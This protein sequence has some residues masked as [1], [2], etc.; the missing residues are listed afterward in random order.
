MFII[1]SF[2]VDLPAEVDDEYWENNDPT[3][4]FQQPYGKPAKVTFF[5]SFVKLTH[6]IS[7]ALRTIV[8]KRKLPSKHH[9]DLIFLQYAIN[10]SKLKIDVPQGSNWKEAIV[11]KMNTMMTEWV[12]TVPQHRELYTIHTK[13][14]YSFSNASQMVT[15]NAAL[16][17]C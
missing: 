17:I 1:P 11:M 13:F 7:T 15:Y 14:A 5:N 4:A 8:S 12:D 6:V 3:L 16:C 2:D 9:A 10:Q